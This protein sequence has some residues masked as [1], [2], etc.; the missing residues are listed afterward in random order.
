[1]SRSEFVYA[2]SLHFQRGEGKARPKKAQRKMPL[3]IRQI[4]MALGLAAF[5]FFVFYEICLFVIS[6]KNLEIKD[7]QISCSATVVKTEVARM[8]QDV[9]G[10]NILLLNMARLKGR[11]ESTPWVKEVRLRKF[12]PSSIKI[13]IA[14]SEPAA[15]LQKDAFYVIDEEG[16]ELEKTGRE[17]Y[18]RLPIFY[19]EGHFLVDRQEKIRLAWEC[20]TSLSAEDRV[21]VEMLDLSEY[22]NVVLKFRSEPTRLLLG[23]DLFAQ[24][25]AFYRMKKDRLENEFGPLEYADLR[26]SDRIYFK[27]AEPKKDKQGIPQPDKEGR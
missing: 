13:E 23:D 26:V 20:L 25:I 3:R 12:F 27:P 1:M 14:P 9:R 19:D 18:A 11:I 6:W 16:V 22:G 5:V 2:R 7:I 4:W 15:L 17:A 8:L 24:K 10:A 21:E